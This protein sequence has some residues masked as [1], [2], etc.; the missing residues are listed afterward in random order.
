M[1]RTRHISETSGVASGRIPLISLVQVLAVAEHL[2]FRHAANVLGVTQSSVSTRI[3]MLE[4]ELGILLFERHHRGVRLTDAGRSFV[5]EVST[6]IGHLDHAIKT[7]G[8]ASSGAVGHIGIGLVSSI[9]V[10][11]LA[12]LRIR[13]RQHYPDIEPVF[14]EGSSAR[15]IALVRDGKLDVA[16]I[17]EPVDASDCHSRLLWTEPFLIALPADH[18]LA[19]LE[20]VSWH[21]LSQEAFLIKTGG[22]GPQLFEHVV[23]RLAERGKSPHVRRCDIGRDT[24]M[25]MV[26]AGEG[27]TLVSETAKHM[28]C[29]GVAFRPLADE[30]ER[31]RFSAVWSPHNRSP[32]LRNLLD[33]ASEMSRS[34]PEILTSRSPYP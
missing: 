30:T 25:Y 22:A 2:N 21:D 33:L 10:G 26:A 8:A 11:F 6:G 16:L 14:M 19:M 15:T 17:L 32:V 31:A 9:T 1:R 23:R 28:S 4:E 27:V 24:L 13:F 3:R 5:A 7:A 34:A 12:G 20:S 29:P 18:P